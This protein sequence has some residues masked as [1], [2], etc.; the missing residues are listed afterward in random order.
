MIDRILF[1]DDD[2]NILSAIR[3][4]FH[5]IF[6]IEVSDSPE[7]ALALIQSKEEF[8]VVVSD[9]NMPEMD[10]I[11]FLSRV[12][13]SAPDTIRILLTG[14]ADVDSAISAVNDSNIFRF[15]TK[16][17]HPDTLSKALK[18]SLQQYKLV[19]AERE[20][21][22]N[23]LNGIIR[24][25]VSIL[26]QT[27]LD[28]F[29]RTSRITGY[30]N[31]IATELMVP[32]PWQ[33]ELAAMLSQVGYIML[34]KPIIA[35]LNSGGKLTTEERNIYLSHPRIAQDM[36]RNIP[37]LDSVAQMIANQLEPYCSPG[38]ES[39]Q[40]NVVRLGASMLKI[41]LDYDTQI[42]SGKSHIES[43]ETLHSR[44]D[45]YNPLMVSILSA[46]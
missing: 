25:L 2:P 1:V 13:E 10:G 6:N 23:T 36:L 3:R 32:D 5:N 24:V 39:S 41:A 45:V 28:A 16:P 9:L 43:I 40:S 34:P 4:Q 8:A 42:I 18:A 44:P 29:S 38:S 26:S 46:G 21:L 30:V 31:K 12:H 11:Q 22:K 17:V 35:T 20:L 37:R 7:S 27:S 14:Y 15:L 33:F 19:T